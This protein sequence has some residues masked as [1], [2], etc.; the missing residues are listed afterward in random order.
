[1]LQFDI[2]DEKMTGELLLNTPFF[3]GMNLDEINEI[4]SRTPH[5]VRS[6]GPGDTI[7][8]SGEEVRRLMIVARGTVKGEMTDTEGRVIKIENI[9]SKMILAPAFMFG[10]MNRYPVNV[11]S[12]SEVTIISIGRDDLLKLL[13]SDNRLLVNFLDIISNR[14][15][16]LSEKIRFLNFRTIKGKLAFLILQKA[17]DGDTEFKI[18]M[19]QEEMAD[20]FGVARP[21]LARALAEME[22]EGIIRSDRGRIKIMDMP[23]LKGIIRD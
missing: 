7:V 1:M 3:R 15:Q 12:I 10:G 16:F 2:F 5:S 22:Q 11:V 4:L 23:R 13:M 21:S 6:Y 18:G 20:Y 14:A 19:T 9:P 8:R 17:G